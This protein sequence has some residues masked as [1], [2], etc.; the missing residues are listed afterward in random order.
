MIQAGNLIQPIIN[1]LRDRLLSDDI[2]H[3]D[4]TTV[5][6]LSE[7][8]KKAQSKSYLWVQ[9]GGSPGKPVILFDYDVGRSQSVPLRL[10]EGFNGTIQ[11]D[12]YAGYNAVVSQNDLVHLVRVLG[13]RT[14]KIY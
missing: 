8:G 12:G 5:Q 3:L 7:P 2:L 10:L 14:S 11:T 1:L 9:R 13:A 6:V 4:E